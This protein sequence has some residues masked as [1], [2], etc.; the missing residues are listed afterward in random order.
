M[1]AQA[2]RSVADLV[3]VGFNSSVIALDRYTGEM[4]W[5]W[6][7]PKGTGFVALLLDGDRLIASAQGYMYCLDPMFGQE[8]WSN[9]LEGMG[10]GTPCL[11]SINGTTAS[12]GLMSAAAEH[13][14]RQ[15][16][17]AAAKVATTH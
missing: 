9:P 7:S 15:E 1:S 4:V 3:F 10:V 16:Q 13:I 2:S 17:A 5:T 6:K 8:V 11:A 14:H 12:S